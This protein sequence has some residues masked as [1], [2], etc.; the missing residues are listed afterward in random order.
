MTVTEIARL[1]G[2]SIGTV[3]R[4]LHKRG[5]VSPETRKKIEEIIESGGYQPNPLARHLKRNRAYPIGVLI[6]S[7]D[8]ES[9]YWRQVYDGI[10]GAVAE[11]SAFSF[12]LELFEFA[13][14][15]RQSLAGAFARLA[16]ADCAAWIIAPVVQADTLACLS[17]MRNPPPY[18]FIDSLLP[19]SGPVTAVAQDPFRGGLL[20]G[21]LMDLLAQA[22]PGR[23]GPYAVIRPYTEAFNL[24]ER[25]RGFMEWC[26]EHRVSG[27]DNGA[28]VGTNAA[29]VI[30]L[31]CPDEGAGGV[32]A[33]LDETLARRADL[34]GIFAVSSLGHRVAAH[35]S[36]CG[37]KDRL[38]IVAYDLVAE[39]RARLLD[40]SIDCL[41]AQRPEEQGRLVLHQ[42]YRKLVLDETPES[43]IE[44][45]LDVYFKENLV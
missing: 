13:R 43:R 32:E 25:R 39:N 1:A 38:A 24:N 41:I 9:R 17:A 42:L 10:R 45:P 18:A 2:V 33:L 30:D 21:R 4:V 20:A 8:A 16:A 35:V 23:R 40:G 5:R 3:D 28:P 44:I 27:S 11:L 6:P 12:S 36:A 22:G 15:D 37:W 31:V 29:E 26:A 19:G 14:A 34:R 7:L